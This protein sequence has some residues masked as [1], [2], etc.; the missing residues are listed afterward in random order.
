MTLLERMESQ[1]LIAE[2]LCTKK[3]GTVID[4]RY[5]WFDPL[6]LSELKA[7]IAALRK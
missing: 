4:G 3:D 6:S 5:A 2:Q 1:V 7:V